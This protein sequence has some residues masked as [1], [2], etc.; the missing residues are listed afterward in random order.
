MGIPGLPPPPRQLP[1]PGASI[2][3]NPVADFLVGYETTAPI[4]CCD[5]GVSSGPVCE[6]GSR[7]PRRVLYYAGGSLCCTDGQIAAHDD[8]LQDGDEVRSMELTPEFLGRI[9]RVLVPF[10]SALQGDRRTAARRSLRS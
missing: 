3:R 4:P 1:A 2:P 10:A 9:H 7:P 6:G 8:V 5:E